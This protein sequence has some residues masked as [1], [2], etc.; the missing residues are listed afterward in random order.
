MVTRRALAEPREPLMPK[1]VMAAAAAAR[2]P[3]RA[4]SQHRPLA[5]EQ[6]TRYRGAMTAGA[7]PAIRAAARSDA[8]AL[9]ELLRALGYD[10]VDPSAHAQTFRR[11]V[12]HPEIRVL[13][14]ENE[15]GRIIGMLA[16][17]H[18]PQLRLGGT[19][20]TVDELVVTADQR[21]RGVG[22][23]LLEG[24]KAIARELGARRLEL[25]TNRSRETY[26]RGFYTKNGFAEANSAVMRLK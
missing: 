8:D 13:V 26:S 24:A 5:L 10:G 25:M 2:D 12:A 14:A 4:G 7:M 20:V 19:L 1:A 23:A 15:S 21:G 22:R 9:L 17:S 11:I 16:L 18:R 3:A 6:A